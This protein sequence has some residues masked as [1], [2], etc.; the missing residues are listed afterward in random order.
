MGKVNNIV[1]LQAKRDAKSPHR[2]GEARCLNCKHNWA[3]VAPIGTTSLQ[4]PKCE[5]FQ[6]LFVG[7]SVTEYKQFQCQCGEYVFFID[8]YSPYCAH[9]GERPKL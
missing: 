7:I 4:C 8:E 5:T 2:A 6:G 3:A 1:D 9:C